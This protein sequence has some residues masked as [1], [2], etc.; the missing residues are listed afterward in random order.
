MKRIFFLVLTGLFCSCTQQ[1]FFPGD[2]EARDS[3][4]GYA[5]FAVYDNFI[6][7]YTDVAGQIPSWDYKING[8]SLRTSA[9]HYKMDWVKKDSLV[10][11]NEIFTIYLRRIK[12]GNCLSEVEGQP[13]NYQPYIDSFFE[14]RNKE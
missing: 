3:S 10:L 13:E 14:R 9:L 12:S 2:W 4:G 1:Y 7:I 6:Q 5:E 11:R 8:D